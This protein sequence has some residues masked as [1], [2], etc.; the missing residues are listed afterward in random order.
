MAD[1][2]AILQL[3]FA[4]QRTYRLFKRQVVQLAWTQ[5]PQQT[6]H[7]IVDA[8]RELL[9]Q[10]TALPDAGAVG[11]Q[12]LND[13]RLGTNCGD[14][15]PDI[16]VQLAGHL[17]AHALLGF[18]QALRQPLVTHQLLLQRLIQLAQPLYS[19]AQQ[20]AGQALRQQRKQ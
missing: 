8:E 12:P 14:G 20:Q 2:T 13:P 9:N 18:Q 4:H 1:H 17:A 16:I 3:H 6:A 7:G 15:L 5:A 11:R 10:L 19:G